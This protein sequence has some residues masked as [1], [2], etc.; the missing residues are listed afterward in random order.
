M[1]RQPLVSLSRRRWLTVAGGT[2]FSALS[3]PARPKASAVEI[4]FYRHP[5]SL[6]GFFSNAYLI[7]GRESCVLVDAH[8]NIDEALDLAALVEN[9][10]KPIS[11]FVITHPHPDHYLGLEL[12]GPLFPKAAVSSSEVSLGFIRAAAADWLHF[13]NAMR[14]LRSGPIVLAETVFECLVMPDAESVA[15]VVLFEP[16]TRTLLAGDHALNRQ[17]LWLVEG[18]PFAWRQNLDQLL[19][20]SPSTVLPG[21]GAVGGIEVLRNTDAY[22]KEFI[23][24]RKRGLSSKQISQAMMERYANHAF[25]EALQ[26]SVLVDKMQ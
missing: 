1:S 24:L 18:R 10:G 19:A 13:R 12:L 14:P 9:I 2:L 17:H 20:L 7:E 8:L 22:L 15:P 16:K 25:P 23:T 21:H 5:A 26:Y 6:P 3:S 4:E 11:D